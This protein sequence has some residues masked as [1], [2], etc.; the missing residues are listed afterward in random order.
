MK[1][2][3]E[4]FSLPQDKSVAGFR[5]LVF[6]TSWVNSE[7]AWL[8]KHRVW[9][10]HITNSPL[11]YEKIMIF[12]DASPVTPTWDDVDVQRDID[13]VDPSC[14]ASIFTFA[15]RLGR[16]GN[17]N[18][19][20]WYRSF[21]TAIRWAHSKGFSRVIHIE[22][23]AFLITDAAFAWVNQC[24]A[25]WE[26]VWCEK[27][28]FPE[29]AIQVIA[30]PEME[31][32]HRLFS[33]NYDWLCG[34]CHENLLPFT[35]IEKSL[36]GDRDESATQNVRDDYD[37]VTQV[38]PMLQSHAFWWVRSRN[39]GTFNLKPR[40][41]I[42]G[43]VSGWSAVE[44][45]FVWSLGDRSLLR[46]HSPSMAGVACVHLDIG[47]CAT[48]NAKRGQKISIRIR[49]DVRIDLRVMFRGE[50]FIPIGAVAAGE[51]IECEFFYDCPIRP[52]DLDPLIN[53]D[54]KLA[55]SLFR[56]DI[57]IVE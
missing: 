30:G 11:Q 40:A 16:V 7:A 6:C 20:G 12:D 47:A 25:G 4:D 24:V 35:S 55:I 44:Q 14:G 2:E 39:V 21:S 8:S 56:A 57:L 34:R 31:T 48:W 18:Y 45:G 50:V 28:K 1:K 37:W 46:L 27:Y 54:R 43:L 38:E 42:G 29:M 23:D 53:D 10:D 22:V 19:A 51:C 52:R 32:A 36:K 9:L 5:T 13:L 41:Q 3:P 26:S 17:F 15:D 33:Q 49:D